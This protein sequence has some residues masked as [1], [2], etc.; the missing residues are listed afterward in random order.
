MAKKV[1]ITSAPITTSPEDRYHAKATFNPDRYPNR[2][3]SLMYIEQK[4][5]DKAGNTAYARA[6]YNGNCFKK[7]EYRS[8]DKEIFQVWKNLEFLRKFNDISKWDFSLILGYKSGTSYEAGLW[9]AMHTNTRKQIPGPAKLSFVVDLFHVKRD[10]L[11]YKDL[12]ILYSTG[13]IKAPVFDGIYAATYY[14]NKIKE[15][16]A[17]SRVLAI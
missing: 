16:K 2:D 1:I 14:A 11:H 12:E 13:K 7:N 3:A 4:Y 10:D 8:C 17:E 15:Y 6:F 9:N 5:V